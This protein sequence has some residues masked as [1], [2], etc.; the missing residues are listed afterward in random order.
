MEIKQSPGGSIWV[1][2]TAGTTELSLEAYDDAA[3]CEGPRGSYLLWLNPDACV[4]GVAG[5]WAVQRF[6]SDDE[7]GECSA[8]VLAWFTGLPA[9]RVFAEDAMAR[10]AYPV[11]DGT[12]E[13]AA[14]TQ[15]L[16]AKATAAKP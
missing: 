7:P 16:D 9:A 10:T 2:G 1:A 4:P 11:F 5:L 8:P 3:A 6:R 13:E 15:G 14:A 12:F